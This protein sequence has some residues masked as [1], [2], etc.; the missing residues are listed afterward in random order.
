VENVKDNSHV[1][2]VEL[3]PLKTGPQQSA[4]RCTLT[5]VAAGLLGSCTV[6]FMPGTF[7]LGRKERCTDDFGSTSILG[8]V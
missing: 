7:V 8:T 1:D 3:L 5:I 2:F 6:Y 4:D